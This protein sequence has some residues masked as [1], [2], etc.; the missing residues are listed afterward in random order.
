[1]EA[2]PGPGSEPELGTA[3]VGQGQAV[4]VHQLLPAG[5]VIFL[6]ESQQILPSS[7]G[8]DASCALV[9][10]NQKQRLRGVML[11]VQ[12]HRSSQGA[13]V[14]PSPGSPGSAGWVM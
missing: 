13:E 10:M 9:L 1:M 14:G 2:E 5:K 4:W 11:L 3:L 6:S 7:L 8:K 12:D